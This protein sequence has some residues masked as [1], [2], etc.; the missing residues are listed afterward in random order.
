MTVSTPLMSRPLEARSVASRKDALPSLK[1]STLVIR[2][3]TVS[4]S[5]FA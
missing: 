2:Y 3:I 5:S 4:M 1:D